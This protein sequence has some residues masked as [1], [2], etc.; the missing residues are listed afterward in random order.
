MK[1]M[2]IVLTAET[3]ISLQGLEKVVFPSPFLIPSCRVS[4]RVHKMVEEVINSLVVDANKLE[5][6]ER[7]DVKMDDSFSNPNFLVSFD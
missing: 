3:D 6:R 1:R 2:G 5:N 7:Y 4:S